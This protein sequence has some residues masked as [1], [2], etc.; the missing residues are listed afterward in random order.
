MGVMNIKDLLE[1]ITK[2]DYEIKL[3]KENFA[4]KLAIRK[5]LELTNKLKTYQEYFPKDSRDEII[6]TLTEALK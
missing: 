4:L 5:A 3:E 2:T 1:D 6:K